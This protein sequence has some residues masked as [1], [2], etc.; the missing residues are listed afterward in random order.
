M[1][2]A[3]FSDSYLPQVNGIASSLGLLNEQFLELG[4][5][6]TVFT[7][8]VKEVDDDS[9]NIV[10]IKSIQ[11]RENPPFYIGSPFSLP[12]LNHLKRGDFDIIHAHK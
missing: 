9:E 12:I 7:P 8:K 5:Q 11:I 2:I 4:H 1:K 3:I 10:R 6:V